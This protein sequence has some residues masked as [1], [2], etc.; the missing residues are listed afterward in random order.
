MNTL[1]MASTY[2]VEHV[3]YFA[4]VTIISVGK[5]VH[6]FHGIETHCDDLGLV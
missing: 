4:P 3:M 5:S 6:N 2:K 1:S